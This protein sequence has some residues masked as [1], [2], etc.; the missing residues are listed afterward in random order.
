MKLTFFLFLAIMLQFIAQAQTSAQKLYLVNFRD[1]GN[2]KS[3]LEV[4]TQILSSQAVNRRMKFNISLDQSDLPVNEQYVRQVSNNSTRV[5]CRSRWF[6]NVL[7]ETDQSSAKQIQSLPF[8][9]EIKEVNNQFKSG[10]S[11]VATQSAGLLQNP[12][13][14]HTSGTKSSNA[15]VFDYGL[16]GNQI[17]MLKGEFLHNHGYA[18][19]G[20]TIAVIDAG[21]GL[22]DTMAVFD[23]LRINNQIKGTFNFA[24]PGQSVY[25]PSTSFH[26][27]EVLSTMAANMSGV[28]IGTAPKANY[29]LF[30]TE[31]AA[32][33][34]IIEEYYWV[35]AA[36]YAD[37]VGADIINSSLGYTVFMDPTTSHTYADMDGNTTYVTIGADKAAEKGILVV[38]SA[39]NDGSDDWKYIGAPAD[40]DSVFT[41][42]AVD[43][44]G[45]YAYFSSKGP[46]YDGRIKPT[47][48]AMGYNATVFTP[49][50]VSFASGTSF[51]SPIIAGMSA[52][53]WQAA[54]AL[55]NMQIIEA[56]KTTA[57]QANDPDTL[58]GWG[59]PDYSAAY[60]VLG[61]NDN[62]ES[63]AQEL[64]VY[65]NP[66]SD[67]L[68][69]ELASAIPG[70]AALQLFD[71]T[72]RQVMIRSYS[73]DPPLKF[74]HLELGNNIP[75]GVYLLRISTN[76]AVYSSR[77]IRR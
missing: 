41:I 15:D 8:V 38:N 12:G 68:Y 21:F 69:I 54:P 30:R 27:T 23:S 46:T 6:N 13:L 10:T 64:K 60:G 73:Q 24:Q 26:G 57:S 75:E 1:K 63:S 16:A 31:V 77:I 76:D 50:G 33:E 36:E 9:T 53:L 61:F 42:G 40:G 39:G 35:S 65:P 44:S 20:M 25:D 29:W 52:C 4:P 66:F 59:I 58:M 51:S 56:L 70:K 37:S 71:L 2:Q 48:A 3:H 22:A 43:G 49:Y 28:M 19:Q 67:Q 62:E 32:T 74:I 45:V 47:I 5:L 55:N 11:L 72:G 34:Y 18:G 17:H 7:I 14:R